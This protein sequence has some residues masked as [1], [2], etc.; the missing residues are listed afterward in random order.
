MRIDRFG[1]SGALLLLGLAL[2]PAT[3]RSADLPPLPAFNH[4]MIAISVAD[5]DAE[6][7]WYVE[8]L[9]FTV[10]RDVN[11]G[12]G[13]IFFRWLTRGNERIELVHS[14][15]ATPGAPR[16]LP[17]AHAGIHG[18]THLTLETADLTATKAALSARGV[19]PVMDITE[20]KELGIKVLYLRDPEGNYVEIVERLKN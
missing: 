5:L 13:R 3:A 11:L 14:P 2:G 6:T 19:T 9:G 12:D 20:V 7:D 1:I 18:L 10:E 4:F 16:P 8:K 17:P 15:G